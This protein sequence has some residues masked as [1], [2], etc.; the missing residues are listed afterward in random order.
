MSGD[1]DIN[2]GRIMDGTATLDQVGEEIHELVLKVA[3]GERTVSEDLGHQAQHPGLT[4]LGADRHDEVTDL[5]HLVALRVEDGQ[6][7]QPGGVH[8][9]GL[10]RSG[11]GGA[12]SRPRYRWVRRLSGNYPPRAR[13][14]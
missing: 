8:T 7:D 5:A 11:L 10:G 14:V 1:M 9:A 2:A 12:H 6:A 13:P 3:D 4:G